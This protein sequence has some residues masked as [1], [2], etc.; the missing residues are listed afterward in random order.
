M[1]TQEIYQELKQNG[2]HFKRAAKGSHEIWNHPSGQSI[3]VSLKSKTRDVPHGTKCQ[4]L[5]K[6]RGV[7]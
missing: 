7:A 5:S 4:I 3:V 1:K 6:I 2:W